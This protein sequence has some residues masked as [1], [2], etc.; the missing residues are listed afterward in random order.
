M[1]V[2]VQE[3]LEGDER[4]HGRGQPAVLRQKAA[5]AVGRALGRAFL[6]HALVDAG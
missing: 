1:C 6:G 2:V 5:P 3:A 4:L